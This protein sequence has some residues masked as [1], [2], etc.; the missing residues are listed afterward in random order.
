MAA[1]V[2]ALALLP[3][4][5]D[6]VAPIPV[7]LAGGVADGR[8]LAAALVLGA[9]GVN[10]GTRFLASRESGARLGERILGAQS[11]EALRFEPWHDLFPPAPGSYDVVPRVLRTDFVARSAAD[12]EGAVSQAEALRGE[13]MRGI[14]SGRAHELTPFTGQTAGLVADVRAAADIVRDMVAEAE[15][16]LARGATVS[17]SRRT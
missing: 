14:R 3:Q 11:E 16:A 1:G 5:V 12:R 15:E 4:V 9:A 13:I 6:A 2:G 10:V 7:L 17:G 8:G